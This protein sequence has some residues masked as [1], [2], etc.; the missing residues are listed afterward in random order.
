[1]S[2]ASCFIDTSV[3]TEALLKPIENR[4]K[5]RSTIRKYEHPILPIYAI[6]ELKAG[7]LKNYIWLHN[8]LAETRSF[9]RT[10]RAIHSNFR[11]RHLQGTALEALQVG[12]ELLIGSSLSHASTRQQT[13]VALADSLR[14]SIRR[15]IDVAWR[16]RRKLG[17]EFADELSCFAEVSHYFNEK[18]KFIDDDRRKCDLEDSCCLALGFRK[19]KNELKKLI[20]AIK[21]QHRPEDNKRRSALHLLSN[22]PNR[23]FEDKD[24]KALGDAYFALQ[25][26]Q[27]CS[28]LTSNVADHQILANALGKSVEEYKP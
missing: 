22:T 19:R 28:I 18:T 2:H 1:M 23:A 12:A 10:L 3:L 27:G 15:R 24:C 5:A 13:D 14:F 25:C 7:P 8:R 4:K 16:E 20:E 6:K 26:P 17:T 9:V 21:D 11:Q